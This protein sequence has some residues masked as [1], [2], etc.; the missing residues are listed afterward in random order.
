MSTAASGRPPVIIIGM[1]RSGTSMITRVLERLGLFVGWRKQGDHEA[2]FFLHLNE[3]L[4]RQSGA[5][6]DNPEPFEYLLRNE[7]VRRLC[8]DFLRFSIGAPRAISFLGPSRYLKYRSIASIAEPW[9]WK[10]PRNTF[11]LPVWLELFPDAKVLHIRRHGIDIAQSIVTRR[12]RMCA[13]AQQRFRRWRPVYAL[14][15]KQRGFV[16][17]VRCDTVEEGVRLWGEYMQAADVHVRKLSGGSTDGRVA[18]CRAVDIKYED[19]LADARPPLERLAAFCEL[20]PSPA[21]LDAAAGMIR[22]ERA[23]AFEREPALREVAT[24]VSDQLRRY[25][26]HE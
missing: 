8:A 4:F 19:V 3:W 9:G 6:W 10:D 23:Y 13:E 24:R 7:P 25:G 14:R 15:F 2:L 12:N 20:S 1:H 21:V 5:R 18:D 17:T 11:T 16:D 22:S 26:Y